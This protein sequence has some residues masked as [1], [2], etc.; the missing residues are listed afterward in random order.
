M[1]PQQS[2][3]YTGHQITGERA[4]EEKGKAGGNI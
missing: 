2:P 1:K 3:K 4:W